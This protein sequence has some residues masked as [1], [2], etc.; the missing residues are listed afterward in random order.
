MALGPRLDLRQSQS[1]V[2]TP[3]LQQAIRLL[4]LSNLEVEGFLAAELDRNPLLEAASADAADAATGLDSIADTPALPAETGGADQL[5]AQGMGAADAPL[6]V[7]HGADTFIDDGPGDRMAAGGGSGGLNDP[8][9]GYG[10]EA[11]DFDSFANPEPEL[12]E[13]LMGQARA[14]LDGA[15]LLIAAQLIGQIDPAGYLDADLLRVAY[16]LGVPLADVERVLGVV[17]GFD[18]T[19]VGARS[20]AECL[21]LQA[22]E[23]DRYDPCIQR[24]LANL[25]LLARGAL[26]QLRRICGVDEE[27][28][29]D[30]IRELRGYD[31][32][33][34]LR[35]SSDRVPAIVPDLFIRAQGDGWSIEINGATLP[36]LLVN[37]SYYA[38]LSGGAQDKASKAWLAD[39]LA[40]ANWLVKALDQRQRTIIRVATEIVRQ[41]EGFF[42]HG[43]AHL[44]PLTLRMVADAID[45]HESTVSRVTSNK[46]LSCARGLYE[47]KYFFTSGIASSDGGAAVSAEAVKSHIKALIAAEEPHAILSDD[48]LVDLLRAKG[49]DIA[50]RTV[51]KYREA[52]GIGS[53]VQRRRQ[54]A[55]RGKAA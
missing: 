31:P 39:C 51:A 45:M 18:P 9:S 33:P 36:R 17:Q 44:K 52:M 42:R 20:L 7:D 53:S 25:D 38:E 26:P 23:A 46:Y 1:L 54:K 5:I 6:D 28:L 13:Y 11:P 2:M 43:V 15:D 41:Q 30:M 37:R 10:S 32:K 3:Q 55:L 40:S 21:A 24:L 47:L 35:F 12:Q 48:T 14:A 22:R 16:A 49:F 27:D 50:R 8:L 4:A 29:T 34:G 19:G